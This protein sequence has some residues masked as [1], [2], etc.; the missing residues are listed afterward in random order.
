M[1]VE[2]LIELLE[3]CNPEA[4]VRFASQPSWPFEYSIETAIEVDLDGNDTGIPKDVVYLE[5][6]IQIG[7]LP[8]LA[9][10]ELSW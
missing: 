3:G 8:E 4:E 5:E 1:R 6:G 7:Y 2:E 10:F 9:K